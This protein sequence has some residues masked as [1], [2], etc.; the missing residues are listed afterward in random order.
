M[1][2][3]L[4]PM[5]CLLGAWLAQV[6][7]NRRADLVALAVISA[8]IV[9]IAGFR[10]YADV[11]YPLYVEMYDDN[12]TLRTFGVDA[13]AALYG[14]PGYLFLTAVF[15]S[16]DSGFAVLALASA[17]LAVGLKAIAVSRLTRHASLALCLYLCVHFLTNEF[18]QLR[19]AV[20]TGWIALGFL[21][22]HRRRFALAA[23][24]FVLALAFHYFAAAFWL[25]AL[26]VPFL[27]GQKRLYLLFVGSLVVAL[28]LQND[29]VAPLLISD[30]DLYV[31]A[32]I[33]RYAANPAAPLGAF[34]FLKLAMYAVIY[35][36]CVRLRPSYPW[37]Q[38]ALNVFLLRVSFLA[39]CLTLAL[40]FQPILHY[41]ATVV[42]DLFAVILVLNAI[43]IAAE[44]RLRTLAF[45][46]LVVLFGTWYLLDLRNNIAGGRIYAY[47]S[48]L[49]R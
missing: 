9:G 25:V 13:V 15:K 5:L 47:R 21:F 19:W 24:C 38:D 10:W 31:L 46:G 40:T 4:A 30:S 23:L 17:A 12:P 11:D 2:V 1:D 33:A 7:R 18:I 44:R 6:R 32:R 26:L 34:S 16:L 8:V 22:Q 43:G 14:E 28:V 3:Y 45:A 48:W 49:A 27:K 20:A 39:I 41:R 35:A 42:A 29:R 36:A 37:M